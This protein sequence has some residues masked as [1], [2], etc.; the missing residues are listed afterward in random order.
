MG[1]VLCFHFPCLLFVVFL[2][3]LVY[4]PGDCI[5]FC[6]SVV[7]AACFFF[8]NKCILSLKIKII[9]Y[10][11]WPPKYFIFKDNHRDLME[12]MVHLLHPLKCVKSHDRIYICNQFLP[13]SSPPE[14]PVK[15]S[16]Y[17]LKAKPS[18]PKLEKEKRE[19]R[20]IYT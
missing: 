13:G 8:F 7:F 18:I 6:N 14:C 4:R 3:S 11:K 20:D 16:Q 17:I 19:E 12:E 1:V 2:Y 10:K 9:Y 5:R 15:I